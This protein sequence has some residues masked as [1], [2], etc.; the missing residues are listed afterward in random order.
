MGVGQATNPLQQ[1]MT[2]AHIFA[3]IDLAANH[4]KREFDLAKGRQ[5]LEKARLQIDA[6]S[7]WF[8]LAVYGA[9]IVVLVLV[10]ILFRNKPEILVPVVTGIVG[11]AGGFG[12]GWGIARRSGSD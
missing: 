10:L 7:R 8:G 2:E 9:L 12:A 1:K 11:G 5:E 4:D 3:V 6:S